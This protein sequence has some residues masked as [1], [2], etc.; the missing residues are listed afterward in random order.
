[1]IQKAADQR[2]LRTFALWMG[3]AI[4]AI[5]VFAMMS[6]KAN[7]LAFIEHDQTRVTWM[8]IA[9]FILGVSVSLIQAMK[10]TAEWFRAYRIAGIVEQQGLSGIE[11]RGGGHVVDHFVDALHMIIARNGRADV[12]ALIDVEFSAQHRV[13]QFVSL[14]GNLMI[15]LGLIG[16]VL[17]M[18]I[19]MNGLNGALGSLG[20]DEGLLVEGLRNAMNGMGVS[21]YTTLIGSVLG[22]VLLRVFSWITDASINGLQDLMLRT[23]LVHASADLEPSDE[24]DLRAL[25]ASVQHLQARV[26]L[27]NMALKASR[28]EMGHVRKE[29]ALMHAEI[30]QLAENDP[31]RKLAAGHARYALGVRPGLL[32]RIFRRRG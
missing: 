29:A 10:L 11:Q 13:S 16:T 23:C 28:E 26:E 32:S 20:V 21:F 9:M 12:D 2:A 6:R 4:S 5:S 24:R 1:M 31:I 25:D 8:I 27:L 14:L 19:T 17:G 7:V 3:W 30:G 15:T 18:T 22:G